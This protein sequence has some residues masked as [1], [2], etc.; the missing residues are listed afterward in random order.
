MFEE[1]LANKKR[2]LTGVFS[3]AEVDQLTDITF[4]RACKKIELEAGQLF[5]L[6]GH[7]L[8]KGNWEIDVLKLDCGRYLLI[9]R[10]ED[11][12]VSSGLFDEYRKQM[13][14]YREYLEDQRKLLEQSEE[15]TSLDFLEIDSTKHAT[16]DSLD[17]DSTNHLTMEKLNEEEGVECQ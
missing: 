12:E 2:I 15:D 16:L 5:P 13:S 17:E 9:D 6:G 10:Q 3:G 11:E 4:G 8:K 14:G 1:Q 7:T